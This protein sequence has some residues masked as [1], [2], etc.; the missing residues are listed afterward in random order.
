MEKREQPVVTTQVPA[1][2][3]FDV[4]DAA[5]R[6]HAS[7]VAP[8]TPFFFWPNDVQQRAWPYEDFQLVRSSVAS[9]AAL[10]GSE[11]ESDLFAGIEDV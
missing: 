10:S 8:D 1:G 7:Q 2:G 5:L 11:T 3:F 6:A 4:R 9:G